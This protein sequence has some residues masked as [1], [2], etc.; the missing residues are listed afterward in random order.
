MRPFSPTAARALLR[1]PVLG[2][3]AALLALQ[4]WGAP[5]TAAAQAAPGGLVLSVV[6]PVLIADG[7]V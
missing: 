3:T 1:A 4:L 5:A 2:L 6:P 7:T